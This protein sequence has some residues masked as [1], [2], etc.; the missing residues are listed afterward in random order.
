M[1]FRSEIEFFAALG[2]SET[3]AALDPG[4]IGRQRALAAAN[5]RL[6]GVLIAQGKLVEALDAFEAALAI[7]LRSAKTANATADTHYDLF[8]AYSRVGEAQNALGRLP[9]ALTKYYSALEICLRLA[10][11]ER[12]NAALQRDLGLTHSRIGD[13][14]QAQSDKVGA[15]SEWEKALAILRRLAEQDPRNA[16][17]Q[18]DLAVA[19]SKYGDLLQSLEKPDA[20]QTTVEAGRVVSPRQAVAAADSAGRLME[21]AAKPPPARLF[22]CYSSE[23]QEWK[24]KLK[25]TLAV[26]E[27]RGY[28]QV[29]HD[30][31][32]GAGDEW[33]SEIQKKLEGADIVL[34]LVSRH[35]LASDYIQEHELPKALDL[36][37]NGKA[38][39]IPLVLTPCSWNE[40]PLYD[41]QSAT[42]DRR[43]VSK[44]QHQEEAYLR[45]ERQ[46]GN[47]WRRLRGLPQLPVDEE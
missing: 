33:N 28:I 30:R 22:V 10:D 35:F 7:S 34:C 41:L 9:E 40:T 39:L 4:N 15:Q 21:D 26:L 17:W 5:S 19:S 11:T 23:D 12:T 46:L 36:H 8:A 2:I 27:K 31:M 16:G 25:S 32:V 29:W 44:W 20:A 13:L 47:V 42:G 43:P 37:K 3:L 1:L 6:G 14:L 38:V 24:R 45:L 18:R